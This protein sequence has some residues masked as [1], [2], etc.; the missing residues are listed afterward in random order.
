MSVSGDAS[1]QIVRLSLE[2][3]DMSKVVTVYDYTTVYETLKECKNEIYCLFYFDMYKYFKK[4]LK[5][6][7]EEIW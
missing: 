4:V 6:K 5:E 1:E 7:G 3:V 2:G